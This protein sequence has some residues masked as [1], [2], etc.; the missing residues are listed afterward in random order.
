MATV[1]G[2]THPELWV[3]F[4]IFTQYP[5]LFS[6]CDGRFQWRHL[7]PLAPDR[8]I[9]QCHDFLQTLRCLQQRLN[10]WTMCCWTVTA[11]CD[12]RRHFF[13]GVVCVCVCVC[14]FCVCYHGY[15]V[16]L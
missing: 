1:N 6:E 13:F 2:Q 11:V 9:P 14:V 15:V 3:N 16:C 4:D 10:R 8:R 12:D 7:Q 5:G